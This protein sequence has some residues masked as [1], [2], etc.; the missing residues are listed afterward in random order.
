MAIEF[1]GIVYLILL[2]PVVGARL[3]PAMYNMNLQGR[4]L[5]PC[6]VPCGQGWCCDTYTTC[7][8]SDTG[9]P[10]VCI[11]QLLTNSD[12]YVIFSP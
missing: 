3:H 4:Q 2:L 1:E 9:D 5:L 10:Y 7:Q 11:D 12:G 8:A 6:D